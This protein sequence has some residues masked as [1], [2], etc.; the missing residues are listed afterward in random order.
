MK[1][2]TFVNL[3]IIGLTLSAIAS[4][5]ILADRV[6][7]EHLIEGL[8]LLGVSSASEA[9][10]ILS[11]LKISIVGAGLCLLLEK[12]SFSDVMKTFESKCDR[13]SASA[14]AEEG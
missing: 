2:I 4:G 6:I 9:A 10:H 5:V 3:F 13:P 8:K 12:F 11:L 1:K 14:E 7:T